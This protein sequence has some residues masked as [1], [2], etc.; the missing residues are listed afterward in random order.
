MSAQQVN[1][2]QRNKML[3]EWE[4]CWVQK[5]PEAMSGHLSLLD[6]RFSTYAQIVV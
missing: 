3:G 1:R 2:A 4:F 5:C 6:N